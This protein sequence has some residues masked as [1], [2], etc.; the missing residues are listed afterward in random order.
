MASAFRPH[1]RLLFHP[2]PLGVGVL[3]LCIVAESFYLAL[4]L[5]GGALMILEQCPCF[6]VMN[7][8]KLNAFAAMC[9]ALSEKLLLP[10]SRPMHRH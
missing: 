7:K 8:L 10:I 5:A 2:A 6:S 9:T 3:W 1:R 4:L